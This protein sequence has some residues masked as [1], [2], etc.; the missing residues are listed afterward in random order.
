[1]VDI[2]Q[3]SVPPYRSL[4]QVDVHLFGFKI[5][6]DA[7]RSKFAP[8]TGLLVAAP[9]GLHV[10]RLHMVYPYDARAQGLHGAHSFENIARPNRSGQTV[11]R[12]ICDLQ[13]V[14]FIFERNHRGHRS[15]DFFARN[16]GAV[17]DVIEDSRLDIVTLS[18]LVSTSAASG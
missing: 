14:L 6:F 9:R 12:I 13:R 15:K 18:K 1:M 3:F 7:P 16:A 5:F 2:S 4:V 10:S 17:I 11:G 8:E